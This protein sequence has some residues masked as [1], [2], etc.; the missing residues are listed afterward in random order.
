MPLLWAKK[1]NPS[2]KKSRSSRSYA[3]CIFPI[4]IKLIFLPHC[5]RIKWIV[6]LYIRYFSLFHPQREEKRT[7]F[8]SKVFLSLHILIRIT[9]ERGGQWRSI[10]LD[11]KTLMIMQCTLRPLV[12]FLD[13]T[14]MLPELFPFVWYCLLWKW[15]WYKF[16]TPVSAFLVVTS[17]TPVPI[18]KFFCWRNKFF[19][20]SC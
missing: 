4:Y 8:I 15:K 18:S 19:S 14:I 11:C 16:F 17:K 7:I 1:S 12:A 6:D 20:N 13:N 2:E 5:S 9:G 10:F 3:F